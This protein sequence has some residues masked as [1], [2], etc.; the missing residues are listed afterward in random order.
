MIET[1]VQLEQAIDTWRACP[2]IG[3]DT[4]F[5]RERTWLADLGLVQV[6]EGTRVWLI[7]PLK[8]GSLQAFSGLLEHIDTVKILHAASEDLGV[9]LNATGTGPTPLFDTQIA[10]ALLGQSLQMGYHTTVEWLLGVKIE[11]GETRSNWCKRPLRPA[12]L[13]YAALDVCLLPVMQRELQR[14][15]QELGRDGWLAEDCE[16][17]IK[18]AHTPSDPAIAWMRVGG[19]GRLDGPSLAILK[20]LA[21]WR[22]H[23][24]QARNLA[25]GFVISDAAMVAIAK[26]KPTNPDQLGAIDVLHPSVVR[27]HAKALLTTITEV[28]DNGL[29][30]TPLPV[31]E[32]RH[33]TLLAGMRKL[34]S[35]RAT[36]LAVE[37]ALLA[38]KRELEALI[39]LDEGA[40]IPDKLLGWRKPLLTD[41]L[42]TMKLEFS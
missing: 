9:L 31:L 1:T 23:E 5:V 26:V 10:C 30:A 16:L 27:R 36:E 20:A 17:L 8:I 33:R 35:K 7:D 12:Q 14:R 29:S 28:M 19:N 21:S 6:S 24:A 39:L 32:P 13:R 37:P 25:R 22:D 3:V 4:E 41:D 18:K 11:K 34:V 42:M 2:V 40:P 38:S 15:L